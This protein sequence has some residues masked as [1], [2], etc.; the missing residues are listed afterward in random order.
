VEASNSFINSSYKQE[1]PIDYFVELIN[2]YNK[3]IDQLLNENT[4]LKQRIRNKINEISLLQKLVEKF[5]TN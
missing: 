5:K 3:R 2:E 1:V 4:T